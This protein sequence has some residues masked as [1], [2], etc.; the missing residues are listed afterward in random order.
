[1][2]E[3]YRATDTRLGRTIAIK[4]LPT[5][6]RSSRDVQAR[7]DREAARVISQLTHPHICTLHDRGH[8]DG[9]DFL[10]MKYLAFAGHHSLATASIATSLRELIAADEWHV[11]VA[12]PVVRACYF[13]VKAST[14]AK[15]GVEKMDWKTGSSQHSLGD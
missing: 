15:R 9:I 3:V 7:F 12:P 1:M 14:G 4:I 13:A 6:L 2:G 11:R 8:E 5:H 10:V